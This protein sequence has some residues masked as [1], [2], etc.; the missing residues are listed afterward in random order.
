MLPT[1][2]GGELVASDWMEVNSLSLEGKAAHA[3]KYMEG[4]YLF[5]PFI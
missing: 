2:Y 5:K 4:T 1:V 3:E